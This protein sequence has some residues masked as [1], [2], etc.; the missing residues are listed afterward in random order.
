MC[1]QKL[2]K[3]YQN[4]GWNNLAIN[5]RARIRVNRQ[6]YYY[7]YETTANL[8]NASWSHLKHNDWV[9]YPDKDKTIR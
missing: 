5:V 3:E 6:D 7:L 2:K 1:I 4:K 9:L 8:A